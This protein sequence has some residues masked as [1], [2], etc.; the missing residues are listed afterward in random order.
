MIGKK[1]SI[2]VEVRKN[3]AFDGNNIVRTVNYLRAS[4]TYLV[5]GVTVNGAGR[6]LICIYGVAVA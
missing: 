2:A 5:C 1:F 3:G 4:A 6:S